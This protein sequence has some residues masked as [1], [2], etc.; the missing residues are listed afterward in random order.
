MFLSASEE[1]LEWFIFWLYWDLKKR[2]LGLMYT[3]T[4]RGVAC[5]EVGLSDLGSSEDCSDA[6]KYATSF[7]EK[8]FFSGVE[9]YSPLN[10]KGC[11][12]LDEGAM[13]FNSYVTG[14][15]NRKA[16]TICKNGNM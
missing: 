7:N 13:Y 1:N 10:H 2:V 5:S 14:K 15:N 8:A 16:R 12:I 4:D 6:V 3:I 9:A 11:Y